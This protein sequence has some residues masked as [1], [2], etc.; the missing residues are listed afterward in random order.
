MKVLK[1]IVKGDP[2]TKKNHQEIAGSGRRCPVCHKFEKQWVR[3]GK[4]HDA[5]AEKAVWM[6]HPRPRVP[7]DFPINI[8]YRFYMQTHRIVDQSNLIES[9]DDILIEAGIIKDDNSRIVAGHDGT[10]VLYDHD[11]P[12][13]EIYITRM[14]DEAPEQID[15][16]N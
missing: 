12:R 15:F 7:I 2:R 1:Y 8:C 10:R 4:A 13:V 5:Y 16:L 14:P 6:L 9:L 3:Q 11:N